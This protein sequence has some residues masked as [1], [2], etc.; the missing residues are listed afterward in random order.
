MTGL[1]QF[2]GGERVLAYRV[3]EQPC[4]FHKAKIGDWAVLNIDGT[5]LAY[6]ENEKFLKTFLPR[7]REAE[8][9]YLD[10]AFEKSLPGG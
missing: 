5:L 1:F 3:K 4:N 9:L 8:T 6:M 2:K 7:D 10:A